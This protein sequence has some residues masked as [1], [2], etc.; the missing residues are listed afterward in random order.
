MSGSAPSGLSP[1]INAPVHAVVRAG[2]VETSYLRVGRGAPVLVLD[3]RGGDQL[4]S[5]LATADA[6]WA[7]ILPDR[8]TIAALA[9]PGHGIGTPFAH[10]LDGFL[11]GL[12]IEEVLVVA[13][14]YLAGELRA[15]AAEWRG[16]LRGVLLRGLP[17]D[18]G[19]PA[20]T[21]VH[22]VAADASWD[23]IQSA[24]PSLLS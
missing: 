7:I 16:R 14:A 9:A 19:M 5:P 12:G 17:Q 15:F 6:R 13:P 24:L 3:E 21:R 10:W 11:Q 1:A 4:T 23:A 8:T 20:D 22:Y 2:E 18:H